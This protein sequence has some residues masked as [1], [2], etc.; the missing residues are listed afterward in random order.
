MNVF[1]KTT[2]M[3]LRKNKMRTRVTL[4]GV[5]LF[6]ATITG[7]LFFATS[8][9]SYITRD[10]VSRSGDWCVAIEDL[11]PEVTRDITGNKDGFGEVRSIGYGAFY[12]TV[13]PQKPYIFVADYSDNMKEIS[14]INL[15]SGRMPKNSKEVVVSEHLLDQVGE[16]FGEGNTFSIS[17]GN[18]I[19]T[20]EGFELGQF[21]RYDPA[22]EAFIGTGTKSYTVVG[23]CR[24]TAI[25]PYL[26][27]GYTVITKDKN[28]T[29]DKQ[30]TF[31]KSEY[32]EKI[33]EYINKGYLVDNNKMHLNE[34]L[35][36]LKGEL[37]ESGFNNALFGL[38]GVLI[39][40]V[41]IGAI[42]LI[43]NAFSISVKERGRQL[44]ILASAG[45]TGKQLRYTIIYEGT[46]LGMIGI[47]AGI[48]FGVIETQ[49]IINFIQRNTQVFKTDLGTKLLLDVPM[50]GLLTVALISILLLTLALILPAREVAK[51]VPLFDKNIANERPLS[52][53]EVE[54]HK[55]IKKYLGTEAYIAN[56]NFRR[57]KKQYLTTIISLSLSIVVFMTATAFSSYLKSGLN[58]VFGEIDTY[59]IVYR[60][61]TKE[62]TEAAYMKLSLAE[63][64]SSSLNYYS[65]ELSNGFGDFNNIGNVIVLD[66]K[67]FGE[68]LREN[69]ISEDG[70]FDDKSPK[71]VAITSYWTYNDRTGK[72]EL[73]DM[74]GKSH[75]PTHMTGVVNGMRLNLEISGYAKIPPKGVSEVV[76]RPTV[77]ASKAAVNDMLTH[78]G[79]TSS[80]SAAFFSGKDPDATFE[81]MKI[82]CRENGFATSKLEN[83]SAQR[84]ELRGLLL[85]VKLFAYGFIT[86][87][88]LIAAA[89]VINSI[90]TNMER[91]KLEFATYLAIGMSHRSFKKML[92]YE[93]FYLGFRALIA[94][95]PVGILATMAVYR[96]GIIAPVTR[97]MIPIYSITTSIIV[98]FTIVF[99]TMLFAF[100]KLKAEELATILKNKNF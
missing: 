40:L 82:I 99:S 32:Y 5:I 21:D 33:E 51:T 20:S 35:L 42:M 54:P 67:S 23:V 65:V 91:R 59:D 28:A 76:N 14:K 93:T 97:Y 73:K 86:L 98:V 61:D 77:I 19:S 34:N 90:S 3:T 17:M 71:F 78:L 80:G 16:E 100:R 49:I 81:A 44:A 12:N 83:T 85:V 56:K 72:F 88:S 79:A 46:F 10:M 25:E 75:R 92:V 36:K 66:D 31:I 60:G 84:D 57:N 26:A 95:L 37:G 39:L 29:V 45:A 47:P 69:K 64:I 1:K 89:N 68:Y 41:L 53:E 2:V 13:N 18:R 43:Y 63:G 24:R 62:E 96:F 22:R 87:L 55:I 58:G 30:Y 7:I 52:K 8:F 27:P 70:M 50:W 74:Y 15:I 6:V 48:C 11:N 9:H 38:A 94:G 4:I